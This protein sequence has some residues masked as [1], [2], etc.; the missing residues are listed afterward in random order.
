MIKFCSDSILERKLKYFGL[1]CTLN[2]NFSFI[3]TN[4]IKNGSVPIL[5]G[6][7]QLAFFF[8]SPDSNSTIGNS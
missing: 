5:T 4:K 3:V 8:K 2:K 1:I 6:H 7:L